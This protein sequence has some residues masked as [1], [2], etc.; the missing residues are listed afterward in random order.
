MY[1]Q[2]N[3]EAFEREPALS[4]SKVTT[5][6]AGVVDVGR[7]ELEQREFVK[8]D[9]DAPTNAEAILEIEEWC[10]EYGFVRARESWLA[11]IARPDGNQVRRGLCYRPS[12]EEQ[13]QR[14]LEVEVLENQV[15]S[16]PV[17][18]PSSELLEE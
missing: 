3:E 5:M 18:R 10:R 6:A 9:S 8:V 13:R 17:T 7:A 12:A 14:D 11:V 15:R 2:R 16:M 4:E 1:L